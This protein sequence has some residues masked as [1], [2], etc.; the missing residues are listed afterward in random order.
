MVR[1][2]LQD[3][4]SV[5]K[6]IPPDE[7]EVYVAFNSD[8][9]KDKTKAGSGYLLLDKT[10]AEKL[11]NEEEWIYLARGKFKRIMDVSYSGLTFE[12]AKKYIEGCAGKE[13]IEGFIY[14][15]T[16]YLGGYP[17]F[18]KWAIFDMYIK[19]KM[20]D[21]PVDMHSFYRAINQADPPAKWPFVKESTRVPSDW[22]ILDLFSKYGFQKRLLEG[23]SMHEKDLDLVDIVE[24]TTG[25]EAEWKE[26][27]TID[28][29]GNTVNTRTL[30]L[31][32]NPT[33]MARFARRW[34]E[35]LEA[36]QKRTNDLTNPSTAGLTGYH[37]CG[38][39]GM[40]IAGGRRRYV[41]W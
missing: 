22:I 2:L 13:G 7:G 6:W 27:T 8:G 18:V 15:T 33:S 29:G 35:G 34:D 5:R 9:E 19:L 24:G 28:S 14:D 25:M 30:L 16:D 41:R 26:D 11:S 20:W 21:N 39:C 4:S 40:P 38:G 10:A 3:K 37:L 1:Y 17:A 23:R 32:S 36:R 31:T 12:Q